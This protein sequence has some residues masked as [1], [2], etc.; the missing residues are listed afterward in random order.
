MMTVHVSAMVVV[1][2][3][4]NMNKLELYHGTDARIVDMSEEERMQYLQGCNLVIDALYPLFKP[5]LEWEK[6]EGIRNGEKV[7][8]YEYPLKLRYEQLLNEKGGQYMYINLLEKLSMIGARNNG[9]ELYQYNNLYFCA[10]KLDAM[11]YAQRSYAGGEIGL[12]A[13]RLIQGAEIIGFENMYCDSKVKLAAE[14]IKEFAREGNERPAI[15]TT[16]NIDTNF[17]FSEDGK[18]IDKLDLDEWSKKHRIK[19]RYTKPVDL[20]KC[21]IEL[22]NKEL[23]KKIVEENL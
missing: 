3:G 11:N 19:F 2:F 17:L 20:K 10:S 13:H 9:S 4:K 7:F 6:V 12:N 15:I 22:L 14:K 1:L 21:K 23:Y 18:T 5:L 8:Y 16:R